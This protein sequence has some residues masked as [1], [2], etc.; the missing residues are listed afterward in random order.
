VESNTPRSPN[1]QTGSHELQHLTAIAPARSSVL[2]QPAR[3]RA[4]AA[5]NHSRAPRSQATELPHPHLLR[6]RA[7]RRCTEAVTTARHPR[8]NRAAQTPRTDKKKKEHPEKPRK[9]PANSDQF[10]RRWIER[11]TSHGIAAPGEGDFANNQSH[12]TRRPPPAISRPQIQRG[13]SR[14]YT[15]AAP[16]RLLLSLFFWAI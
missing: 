5:T 1:H 10:L 8:H 14:P 4:S 12:G 16:A 13:E 15:D 9:K 7:A 11:P 3:S 6:W 2:T